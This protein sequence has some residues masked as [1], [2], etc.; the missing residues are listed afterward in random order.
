MRVSPLHAALAVSGLA[1]TITVYVARPAALFPHPQPAPTL[2]AGY[3]DEARPWPEPSLAAAVVYVAGAVAR[4]GVYALPAHARVND[5]VARAGGAS[6][7]A[8]LVAVN[9]AAP[10]EDGQEIAVPRVGETLTSPPRRTRS[11]RKH[12]RTTRRKPRRARQDELTADAPVD[13]N[14]ADADT[15]ATLPGVGATLAERI[16]E[17][18]TLNGPFVSVDGLADVSGITPGKLDKIAPL[19]V[20]RP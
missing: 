14:H 6:R 4:P 10:L 18:R 16:V 1:L 12:G 2:T 17:F 5:A 3:D 11:P 9:L 7:D 20:A 19:L 15:L 13:L 8:D